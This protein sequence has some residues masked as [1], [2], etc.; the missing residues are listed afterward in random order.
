MSEIQHFVFGE[1][2]SVPQPDEVGFHREAISPE[3][4]E[5][6]SRPQGRISLKI[7]TF[8]GRQ[9]PLFSWHAERDFV[10]ALPAPIASLTLVAAAKKQSPGLFFLTPCSNPFR[11]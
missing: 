8:V 4:S 2:K 11:F 10:P 6:L 1:I 5:D 9:K 7:A 3:R